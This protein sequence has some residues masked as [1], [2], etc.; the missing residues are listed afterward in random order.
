MDELTTRYSQPLVLIPVTA[1]FVIIFAIVVRSLKE[2]PLFARG[3]KVVV[4]LCVTVLAMYGLDQT[5]VRAVVQQYTAMGVAMLF[6]LAGLLLTAWLGLVARS[7]RHIR[8]S[9]EN[10]DDEDEVGRNE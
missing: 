6:G 5:I 4:A 10:E 2:M 8:R 1:M 3:G 9:Q 7:R